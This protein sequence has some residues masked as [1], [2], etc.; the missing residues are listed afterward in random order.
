MQPR[1]TAIL[2]ARN[3]DAQ[4]ERSLAQLA[5]Q[6]R[7]V[8]RL[9]LVDAGSAGDTGR[10]HRAAG[11]E[12]V[13][14]AGAT[15]YGEA[16][17][18][19]MRALPASE[20]PSEWLWLLAHDTA[21]EP[22]ALER[23]L[24]AVEV[25]P[26]VAIAGPKLVDWRDRALIRSYGISISGSGE[27]V[28][29]AE[30]ELD[31][32]QHDVDGDVMAVETQGMLVR[33][34]VIEALGGLDQG[35]PSTDAG[36]DL[37]IRARLAGHRVVRVASSRV[38]V[39]AAP[40]D[41]GRRRPASTAVRRRVARA[42]QL[43]RRFVYAGG[44]ALLWIWL[45]LVPLAI[46]RSVLHLLAKR[47]TAVGG[48][49][50]AAFAAAF[51]PNGVGPA[52]RRLR[53]QR[54]VGWG[55]LASLRVPRE[56][57]RERA[58][59][60]RDREAAR[61][62]EDE[63]IVRAEFLTGGGIWVVVAAGLIGIALL[64]RLLGTEA[65]FGGAA[66]PL[67]SD[68]GALWSRLGLGWRDVGTGFIGAAD[69]FALVLAVLG[70]LTF[71][72]PSLSLVLLFLA[73]MPLAALGAWWLAT[74]LSE[75]AWPPAVAA[76]LWA[77]SPAL[78]VS[79]GEGRIP[80]VIA[81]V[82]LP[83]LVLAALEGARS[84]SAAATA[85]L[86]FAGVTASAPS[87][88]PALLV[89][90]LV[91]LF[92]RPR[93][94]LRIVGIPIPAAVLFAP[95]VV[96]QLARG[97]PL[98]LLADPG[99]TVAF[100][101][102]EGWLLAL[103]SPDGA[104]LGWPALLAGLGAEPGTA[105]LVAAA[106]TAP[107]ALLAIAGGF[108][109]GVRAAVAVGL[110][111]LGLATAVA[112]SRLLLAADGAQAVAIWPAPGLSLLQLGLVAAAVLALDRLRR[113]RVALGVLAIVASAGLVAPVVGAGLLDRQPLRGGDG[114]TL[115]ALVSAEAAQAPWLA[116][117]V[118]TP[119]SDGSLAARLERGEGTTLDDTSTLASTRVE[120]S[121]DAEGLAE[122]AGNLASRSGYD[123][124]PAMRELGLEYVLLPAADE[125]ASGEARAVRTRTSQALDATSALQP[126]GNTPSGRLWRYPEPAEPRDI[127]G[128]GTT[129]A[130]ILLVQGVVLVAAALLAV[131]TGR[132]RRVV[133][134]DPLPGDERADTFDED[135]HE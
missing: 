103:G 56:E 80:A 37:S 117:L 127:P 52:R 100:P 107:L 29:L 98:G 46:G 104:L 78:L 11:V 71:W 42:A 75:R 43:H 66:L 130:V 132:R 1:V 88:A 54:S 94:A 31:Q 68:I 110:G 10:I 47:P 135:E 20:G 5:A 122:L 70:S 15:P 12:H 17:E 41:F 119:Q 51:V 35:L 91:W 109:A 13:V 33:R 64:H 121:E 49:F 6:T 32:S 89:A 3:G 85:A 18:L 50:R 16:L 22:D 23:L 45:S 113:G 77:L 39:A 8:D 57:V 53:A 82:L 126:I 74:R 72:A 108:A 59:T 129:G 87:L 133:S 4:L 65:L 105:L 76:L 114:V 55:A 102:A 25:A 7:P 36:L 111:A 73:A 19:G 99:A 125:G 34:H 40:V 9:I 81:H 38:A 63:V 92:A 58:A 128:L 120:L 101:D 112:A 69:P 2:I 60:R 83:W 97:N 93:A 118:L 124:V 61:R 123:P 134:P 62:G 48:E 131:P 21:P 115:P 116:T 24:A 44:G 14:K 84:W 27:T 26:S 79:L 86:L 67:T 95:L 30:D 90:W 96:Q 28:P 106:L